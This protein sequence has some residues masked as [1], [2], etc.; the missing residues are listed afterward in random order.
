MNPSE[1]DALVNAVYITVFATMGLI[2]FVMGGLGYYEYRTKKCGNN[3]ILSVNKRYGVLITW[4]DVYIFKKYQGG[5]KTIL[6]ANTIV[7]MKT[8]VGP[9]GDNTIDL[10]QDGKLIRNVSLEDTRGH[11]VLKSNGLELEVI[12]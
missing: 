7:G 5:G 9:R 4:D 1:T 8:I 3:G 6:G 12:S 11:W 10:I 2:G